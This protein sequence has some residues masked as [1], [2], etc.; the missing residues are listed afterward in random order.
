[1]FYTP[2]DYLAFEKILA[3][4]LKRYPVDLLTYGLMPNHGHL[5]LRPR[6][7]RGLSRFMGWLGVTHARRHHAHYHPSAGGHV[8]QGRFKSFPLQDD[9]HFLVVCRY[10]EANAVRA[11]L[12]RR[13]RDWRWCGLYARAHAD[14]PPLAGWPVERPSG[15]AALVEESL[16]KKMLKSLRTSVSRGRPF[17]SESWV[18]RWAKRLGLEST[19]RPRG[20]PKKD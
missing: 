20:R 4:G 5:V 2:E 9:E 18:M 8:Y 16:E 1:M 6:T 3:E 17:G 15:W 10:V 13:A 19:L 12:C 14:K 11:R 7:D